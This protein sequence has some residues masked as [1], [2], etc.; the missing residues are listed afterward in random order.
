MVSAESSTAWRSAGACL[1]ADPDLFF[2]ISP[3][4]LGRA[5][6]SHA[7]VICASC[8]VQQQ[9]LSFALET[10]EVHGIWGGTSPEDRQALRRR[11]RAA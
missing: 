2:P 11:L 4:G 8:H 7:K 10:G 9:C 3:A 5:Q 1:T 6:T